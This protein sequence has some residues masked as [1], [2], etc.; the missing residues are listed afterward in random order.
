MKYCEIERKRRSSQR[1]GR[2]V[3]SGGG[4]ARLKWESKATLTFRRPMA[5]GD[6][7]HFPRRAVTYIRMT[8]RQEEWSAGRQRSAL[9]RYARRHGL[10][11][12]REYLE[13]G[14]DG[15]G[16]ALA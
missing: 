9:R 13:G 7:E 16:G 3:P 1:P 2:R 8:V 14:G 5:K 11:I 6:P 15:K 12:V 4:D 10:K